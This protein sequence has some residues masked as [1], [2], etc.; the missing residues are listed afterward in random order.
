[1]NELEMLRAKVYRYETAISMFNNRYY[2][3]QCTIEFLTKDEFDYLDDA[4]ED[5]DLFLIREEQLK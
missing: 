3:E 4:V 1:M 5:C 2:G